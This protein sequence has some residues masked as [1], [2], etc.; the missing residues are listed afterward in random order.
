ME[1]IA[2]V[3]IVA[4]DIETSGL[5]WRSERIG[6]CQLYAPGQ[7]PCLVQLRGKLPERLRL[8]LNDPEVTKLFH[9][10]LFDLRFMAHHWK[11]TPQNIICTK[12]AAKILNPSGK[13]HS[14]ASLVG[15]YL[16]VTLDKRLQTSD[17]LAEQLTPEQIQY[18]VRDVL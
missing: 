17:W 10:A 7:P 16:N 9:H 3:G 13:G 12:I 11:A 6:T 14:L 18:A 1:G 5:D 2:R 15:R 4:W 8:L